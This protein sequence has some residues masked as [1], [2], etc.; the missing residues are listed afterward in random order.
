MSISTHYS[1][2]S[3]H[4]RCAQAW[5][6]RYGLGVEQQEQGSPYITFGQW[7][8]A[9]RAAEGAER[10]RRLESL[11]IEGSGTVT[12]V[13]GL[14]IDL[15]TVTAEDVLAAAQDHWSRLS[16]DARAEFEEALGE[17]LPVRLQGAFTD[18][19]EEFAD[20][21][22]TEHPIA[23]EMY[24]KRALPR[25][26]ADSE[27]GEQ[28]M[29]E[30]VLFG[31]A[32]EVYWDSVREMTVVRDHKTSKNISRNGAIDDMMDSQ[33]HLYAWGLAPTITRWGLKQTSAVGFDRI[34]SVAPAQPV[35]TKA[36][37]LAASV[38]R[39]NLRTYREFTGGPEGEGVPYPGMKK[40]GSGAGLYR[41]DE[42]VAEKLSRPDWR[43]QFVDR[44]LSPLNLNI[45]R[46]HLRA[47]SDTASDM[48]RTSVRAQRTRS[49]ARSLGEAC[50]LCD[51]ADL[52]RAQMIGGERGEYELAE[53]GL[54]GKRGETVL[55][56]GELR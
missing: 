34:Q 4:R 49:A 48:W 14:T 32:D 19:R 27:W 55:D 5:Y 8:S 33:L 15:R 6:Y 2:L 21:T 10:G 37:K 22:A 54:V 11:R 42:T 36:G 31:T 1:G 56:G 18:W 41:Y 23:V 38:T 3:L 25:P 40:D 51:Y 45:V 9:L 52:C 17:P 28:D 29:P 7:W 16:E 50:R 43:A 44:T 46:A 13:D 26:R 30:V 53:F 47:A 24:W 20:Q 39:Y 35:V 12:P